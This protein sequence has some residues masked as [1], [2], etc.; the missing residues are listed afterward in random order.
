MGISALLLLAAMGSASLTLDEA[1]RTAEAHHPQLQQ[2]KASAQAADAR[3]DSSMAPLL[4]QVSGSA[5]YERST[6]NYA[7]RPG[8]LPSAISSATNNSF[9]T[10]N[11]INFGVNATQLVYDFGQTTGRWRAAQASADAQRQNEQVAQLQIVLGVR[12]AFF[13]ARAQKDMVRVAEQTVANQRRHLRQIQGFVEVKT[14]PEIDLAQARLDMANAELLLVNAQSG[15]AS[16]RAQLNLAM[17]VV[18]DADYDV[19]DETF[20]AVFAEDG[21]TDQLTQ[22]AARRPDIL[23]LQKQIHAQELTLRAIQGAYGPSLSIST[24]LT[25]SGAQINNMAWNWNGSVNLSW[26]IFQGHLTH[27]QV[28]EA[29]ANLAGLH[30]QMNALQQS[31][32]LAIEQ[33]R[34]GIRAA[35]AAS[36]IAEVALENAT[37]RLSLA[38]GRYQA[39]VGSIIELGDAQLAL[40]A[41]ASQKVQTDYSLASA[42][43]QLLQ[44]LGRR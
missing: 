9:N 2:A 30:A 25:E 4:P 39:G 18:Q 8:A 5:S 40:T 23:A 22:E 19:A 24:G 27:A 41:A 14:R 6:S 17:G 34:L 42:R 11:Y 36:R 38:E 20:P 16:S 37:Q 31:L 32:R 44:A 21:S 1:V 43:A 26:P 13:A 33:A 28:R 3:A 15:Y 10:N 35:K 7:P 29:E 12:T